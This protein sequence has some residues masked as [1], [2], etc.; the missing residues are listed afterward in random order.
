M[1]APFERLGSHISLLGD[2]IRKMDKDVWPSAVMPVAK[3]VP[4]KMNASVKERLLAFRDVFDVHV[5]LIVEANTNPLSLFTPN[6]DVLRSVIKDLK[7]Q[8]VVCQ[9]LRDADDDVK[10]SYYHTCA[11]LKIQHLY[12][13]EH[14]R[15]MFLVFYSKLKKAV[16]DVEL[17][18][19][20]KYVIQNS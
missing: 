8:S 14:L 5:D 9:L 17:S 2:M 20:T 12:V 15:K 10:E 16:F 13:E 18:E 7:Q 6:A 11:M 19:F 1:A 4:Q 3:D